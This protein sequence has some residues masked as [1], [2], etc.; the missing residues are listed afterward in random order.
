[1]V[2]LESAKLTVRMYKRY[3]D[4]GN[5]KLKALDPG[6]MWDSSLMRV[7]LAMHMMIDNQMRGLR[8]L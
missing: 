3:V 7:V 1:M 4:D 6:A 5:L 2:L 8:R